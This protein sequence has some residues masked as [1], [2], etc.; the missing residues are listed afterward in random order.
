MQL[1]PMPYIIAASLIGTA[2]GAFITACFYAR[3]IHRVSHESWKQAE[4]FYTRQAGRRG[5]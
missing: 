4:I 3:R 1:D 2:S 5:L